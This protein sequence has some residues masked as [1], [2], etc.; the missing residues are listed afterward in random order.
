MIGLKRFIRPGVV[1]S[2]VGHVGLLVLGLHL[3]GGSPIEPVPP[4]AMVVDIVP[5]NEV[6]RLEGTPS[7]LRMSGSETN[8]ASAAA[9]PPPKPAAQPPQQPQRRSNPQPSARQASAPPAQPEPAHA[10]TRQPETAEAQASAPPPA[11]PQPRAE[12]TPDRPS[13]ETF[14]QYALL[15]GRLGGGFAAPPIDT[16]KAAY[17]YTAP[18][19]ER[20][21]SCSTR[22]PGIDPGDKISVALRVTLN[23]DGT[24]ASPPQLLE[25]IASP[26]ERALMQSAI[27]ALQKCQPYSMLPAEKYKQWKTLDLMFFPL[28]FFGG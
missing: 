6:P 28:N 21:S 11:A 25:P 23:P 27:S 16:N 2:A 8:G 10:E 5:P 3:V 14:A 18:F 24:L 7:E 15:G 13:A 19:R 26:K 4:D 20:V 1:V 12:E 9:Q 17:D 22:P